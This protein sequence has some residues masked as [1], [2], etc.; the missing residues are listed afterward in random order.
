[1]PVQIFNSHGYK[2]DQETVNFVPVGSVDPKSGKLTL[3]ESAILWPGAT[4]NAPNPQV[5]PR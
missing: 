4:R 5:R 1:M 2:A 3:D